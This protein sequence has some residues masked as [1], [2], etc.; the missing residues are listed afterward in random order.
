[1]NEHQKR[2]LILLKE[3][4]D[5]CKKYDITYYCTGGTLIG[6]VRHG[7]FIPWDDDIDV[8]MFRNDFFRFAQAFEKENMSGRTLTFREKDNDYHS[9]IPRYVDTNSTVFCK[10]HMLGHAAAGTLIDVF[11][12]D[13]V[14]SECEARRDFLDKFFIYC[15]LVMPFYSFSHRSFNKNYDLYDEYLDHSGKSQKDNVIEKLSKELFTLDPDK[16]DSVLLRWGSIPNFFPKS[17]FGEPVYMDFEDMKIPVPEGWYDYLVQLYGSEWMN[18]PYVETQ[19]THENIKRYDLPYTYFYEKRD[20]MMDPYELEKAYFERKNAYRAYEKERRMVEKGDYHIIDQ[21]VLKGLSNRINEMDD[22]PE[23]SLEKGEY[24]KLIDAF[25]KYLEIQTSINYMGRMHHTHYYRWMNPH[26]IEIPQQYLL[27]LLKALLKS[28]KTGTAEKLAGIY[29]RKGIT[30]PAIDFINKEIDTI[31]KAAFLYYTGEYEKCIALCDTVIDNCYNEKIRG[32]RLLSSAMTDPERTLALIENEEQLTYEAQKALG[33][34]LYSCGHIDKAAEVYRE[35]MKDCRNG[36][37]YNDISSKITIDPITLTEEE[38]F[39]PNDINQIEKKLIDEIVHICN[40]ND[41]D[42]VLGPHLSRR[43][44][45]CGNFGYEEEKKNIYM[46]AKNAQ[47]FIKA[48]QQANPEKRT[49]YSWLNNPAISNMILKYTFTDSVLLDFNDNNNMTEKPGISISIIIIRSGKANRFYRKYYMYKEYFSSKGNG[50][51]KAGLFNEIIKKEQKYPQ[52][53]YYFFTNSKG[54]KPSRNK[55]YDEDWKDRG[56]IEYEGKS[57][58]VPKAALMSHFRNEVKKSNKRTDSEELIYHFASVSWDDIN[59]LT[60][61]N[62]ADRTK[63]N[64]LKK[65]KEESHKKTDRYWKMILCINDSMLINEKYR[66]QIPE[67]RKALLDKDYEKLGEMLSEVDILSKMHNKLDVYLD[68]DEGI[69]ECYLG[70]LTGTGQ[71]RKA[72]KLMSHR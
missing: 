55:Y 16:Y 45:V 59:L 52:G 9:T 27:I 33:D 40:E 53:N 44:F 22:T 8:Y 32:F 4:D 49:L 5:I 6:A 20:E 23:G 66:D 48:F 69:L 29:N 43:L 51:G 58:T 41:I 15:D 36:L 10:Y 71:E 3:I 1:M 61:N 35:L 64:Q 13:P 17:M 42:Y 31:N 7:G 34:S 72:E 11:I 25:S 62:K 26:I 54:K 67:M 39:V 19:D 46:D 37:F 50:R 47:K 18:I 56:V 14:P 12:L 38:Q 2:L 68:I 65:E 60:E 28:N 30:N 70:Y 24:G 21:L 63:L 57:Y